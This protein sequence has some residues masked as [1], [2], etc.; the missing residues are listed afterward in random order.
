MTGPST[1]MA[2]VGSIAHIP[3]TFTADKLPADLRFFAVFWYLEG[4]RILRYDD[5]VTSTDPRYS[6]EEDRALNGNADLTI[7]NTSVSDGG[8]YTC[9]VTYSPLRMEKKIRVDITAIPT[10]TFVNKVVTMSTKS[11]LNST[12][13][14]FYPA[15]IDIKWL[16]DGA[17]LDNVIMEKPQRDPD[18]TYSVRSSVPI[19]PTKKDRKRTF[20]CRVQHESL[21]APLQEDFRLVYSESSSYSIIICIVVPA[22]VI[23]AAVII[24]IILW[25]LKCRRK[26]GGHSYEEPENQDNENKELISGDESVSAYI[27]HIIKRKRESTITQSY[28]FKT[29][30]NK[31]RWNI[32]CVI[33]CQEVFD[34]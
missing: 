12:I 8:D 26:G 33:T 31:G 32:M 16:R 5:I 20:S 7:S 28:K 25:K 23:I 10:I 14:G 34:S 9:S 30:K 17:I 6:L 22:V 24:G 27:M 15:K 19:T 2:S 3:C 1:Y 11:S 18:G 21:T 13:S 29:K 4:K